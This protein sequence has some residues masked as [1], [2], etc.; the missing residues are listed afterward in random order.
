MFLSFWIAL[1][2]LKRG[3]PKLHRAKTEPM[4]ALAMNLVE[5]IPPSASPVLSW[6]SHDVAVPQHHVHA[7][8]IRTPRS[9]PAL[10]LEKTSSV[11]SVRTLE[12]TQWLME[13]MTRCLLHPAALNRAS[14]AMWSEART[15][16]NLLRPPPSME[17]H[18]PMEM[19][20]FDTECVRLLSVHSVSRSV[21]SEPKMAIHRIDAMRT[22]MNNRFAFAALS[23]SR[24][25]LVP[26]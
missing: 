3:M 8:P 20:A 10:T 24:G 6:E 23:I 25:Q 9:A 7:R 17:L 16:P 1:I 2:L 19:T 26:F 18:D 5:G 12:V 13:H 22:E 15:L 21:S 4:H 11:L 14:L